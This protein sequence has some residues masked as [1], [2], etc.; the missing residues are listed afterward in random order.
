MP[1]TIVKDASAQAHHVGASV[2]VPERLS[3]E[4][5]NTKRKAARWVKGQVIF[6]GQNKANEL[7]LEVQT[8]EVGTAQYYPAECPLQNERDD[9]VDDLVK[10]DF[11][12]E[13]GSQ[14]LI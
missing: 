9:T 13:P 8:E 5:P 4:G 11:L 2:W 3:G 7:V 14:L 10:S 12:H 6:V 1:Q